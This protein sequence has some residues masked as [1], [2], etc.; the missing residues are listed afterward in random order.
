[1]DRMLKFL[2]LI[3]G[4]AAVLAV[5]PATGTAASFHS[6]SG[7]GNT[8]IAGEST[9]NH[10]I[11]AAGSTITCTG[12]KFEGTQ[13]GN[14]ASAIELSA[15]YSG[16]TVTVFGFKISATLDMGSCRYG[17]NPDGFFHI[18]GTFDVL[19]WDNV[20]STFPITWKVSNFAGSCTVKI[21][22]E[23]FL[24]KV[25]YTGTTTAAN[26]TI[27]LALNVTGIDGV[28]EGNLC[29]AGAF[30]NGAYTSGPVVLKGFNGAQT[31]IWVT[32]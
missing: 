8:H 9:G 1:M 29:T 30:N 28:A 6:D 18:V 15:S 19:K 23:S 21:G 22:A 24:W 25:G 11:D 26:S 13:F 2:S 10:V 7:A 17:L 12:A 32:H 20:C 31:S 16:C 3:V 4:M 27:A 14:T 5:L